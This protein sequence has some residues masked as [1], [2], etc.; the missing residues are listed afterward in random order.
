LTRVGSIRADVSKR[1]FALL[2][3][4][5]MLAAACASNPTATSVD[6]GSGVR[7]VPVVADS[8]DNVGLGSA[9]ALTADGLPYVTYLGFPA[10]VKEGEIPIPRPI[11]SPFLPGVLLS[12]VDANGV[13]THGAI[14]QAKPKAGLPSG[15]TVPFGPVTTEN[16]QLTADDSNGTAVALGSDGTVHAA[17]TM[18]DGVYY[19]TT[20]ADGTS[21]VQQVFNYGTAVSLAGPISAPGIAL[22]ADGNPWVAFSVLGSGGLEVHAVT[23]TGSKWTDQVVATSG[24]CGGCPEPGPTGIAVLRGNPVVV[25]GDAAKDSVE[26]ATFQGSKWVVNV[27]DAKAQGLGLSVSVATSGNT[28]YASFYTGHGAVRV[29]LLDDHAPTTMEVA[30]APNPSPSKT[31]N[32]AS[33]TAVAAGTDGTIYVA[34]DDET[35]GLQ[36]VSGTDTFTAVE[37]GSTAAGGLHPALAASDSGIY[38]SWYDSVNQNLMVGVQ[39][40]VQNILVANPP[41][42][43][44]P[45]FGASGP[46]NC[47]GKKAVLDV[48]AQNTAFDPTC[49][50]APA[51]S[52]FTINF[53]NK[54]TGATGTHNVDVYDKNPADGGTSLAAL[55]PKPG[56]IQESLPVGALDAGTYYFQCDVHPLQ[57]FGTLAVVKGAS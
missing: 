14:E 12:S 10:V 32:S 1:P 34:W 7:F 28:A 55:T 4:L 31:G 8:L 47:T 53:D 18:R 19:G 41:P 38:L 13:W 51:S 39:G 33:R 23:L 36:F 25:F 26:A 35:K 40:D 46:A 15:I 16:L 2:A 45:S 54:D 11:G 30:K 56:P 9:L 20:K 49:L 21:T 27:V 3:G 43:I 6:F 5:A 48:V 29:A 24:P 17:W 44:V 52:P 42:S 50:I 22:D 37:L 57:M